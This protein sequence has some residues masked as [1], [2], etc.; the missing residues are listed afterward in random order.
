MH[1]VRYP[2]PSSYTSSHQHAVA[3]VQLMCS[4]WYELKQD[5]EPVNVVGSVGDWRYEVAIRHPPIH[6]VVIRQ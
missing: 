3:A 6:P 5:V 4:T 2:T 1:P